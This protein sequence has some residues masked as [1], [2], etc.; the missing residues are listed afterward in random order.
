MTTCARASGRVWRV[1]EKTMEQLDSEGRIFHTKNGMP[2]IK[3]DLDESEDQAL[4]D[5]WT[6]IAP[7]VSWSKERVGYDTQKREGLLERI[8]TLASDPGDLASSATASGFS[9]RFVEPITRSDERAT[10]TPPP[11]I[12]R[13]RS[14][15]GCGAGSA[16]RIHPCARAGHIDQ[17]PEQPHGDAARS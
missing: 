10:R 1:P 11:A 16:A 17:V 13:M 3:S 7:V 15:G 9:N 2:L 14:S 4:G 12:G 5:L 6:D 8:I